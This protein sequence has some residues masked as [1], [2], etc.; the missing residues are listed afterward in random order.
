MHK[1]LGVHHFLEYFIYSN[2]LVENPNLLK[3][4]FQFFLSFIQ[5]HTPT[6]S[7]I[8]FVPHFLLVQLHEGNFHLPY[9]F[10]LLRPS[11]SMSQSSWSFCRISMHHPLLVLVIEELVQLAT[12]LQSYASSQPSY[13]LVLISSTCDHYHDQP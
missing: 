8:W 13:L 6:D 4:L 1:K 5:S 10:S 11:S 7:L 3:K 2:I 9:F 12:P